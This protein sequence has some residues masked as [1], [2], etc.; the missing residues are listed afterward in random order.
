MRP[1]MSRVLTIA[2]AIVPAA[3]EEEYVRI[4]HTLAALG[5][6]R[7][8]RL[9]LFRSTTRPGQYLEFSESP[10]EMTHRT[11]ASRTDLE[12]RLESRLTDLVEYEPG[13][14]DFWEQVP[15]PDPTD[16]TGL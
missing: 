6:E 11:R 8:R 7:S 16:V 10:T 14:F 1:E 4:V 13:T 3:A 15:A 12:V 2:R 5:T 9:W